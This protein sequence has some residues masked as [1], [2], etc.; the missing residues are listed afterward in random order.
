MR[1]LCSATDHKVADSAFGEVFD[2]YHRRVVSWC[3]R[4]AKN[5]D[6]SNDLAQEVFLKAYRHR[7]SFRGDARLSTWLYAIAR[8][9][10]LT[11]LRHPEPDV[12]PY[13]AVMPICL[14]DTTLRSPDTVAEL[15]EL[16]A[17]LAGMMTRFLEP[18]EARVMTLHYAHEI[19]LSAIT[20]DLG[21]RNP[22]GAKAYIVN[23]RRKLISRTGRRQRH[24]AKFLQAYAA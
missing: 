11:S 17:S 5:R 3:Y 22:S 8:N 14:R 2:R 24:S 6:R 20:R 4:I 13:D 9:H 7:H 12:L 21:L 15:R 1:L 18:I 23:A 16:G 19:P 10:C